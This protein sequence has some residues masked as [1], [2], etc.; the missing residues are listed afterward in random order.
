ME[1]STP[2]ILTR[3]LNQ[4]QLFSKRLHLCF[5]WRNFWLR[6]RRQTTWKGEQLWSSGAHLPGW[7]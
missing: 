3:S 6:S 7:A 5:N 2:K 1:G 4:W